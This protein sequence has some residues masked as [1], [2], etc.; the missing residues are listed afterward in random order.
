MTQDVA[1]WVRGERRGEVVSRGMVIRG[2]LC[3]TCEAGG[4]PSRGTAAGLIFSVSLLYS[5]IFII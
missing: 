2:L 5:L 4:G 3:A 1:Q